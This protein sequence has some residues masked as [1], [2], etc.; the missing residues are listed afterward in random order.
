MELSEDSDPSRPSKWPISKLG[1]A[2]YNPKALGLIR[3]QGGNELQFE[4]VYLNAPVP[5]EDPKLRELAEHYHKQCDAY[6]DH[7]CTRWLEVDGQ[8]AKVPADDRQSR[9]MN[10]HAREARDV[11]IKI[12]RARGFSRQQV[13]QAI[14]D[15]SRRSRWHRPKS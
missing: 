2:V 15:H 11:C 4:A 3:Q 7:V 13:L 1:K 9:L 14:R 8:F 12:G 10:E 6:D 5:Q